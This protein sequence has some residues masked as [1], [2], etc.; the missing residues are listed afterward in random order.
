MTTSEFYILFV[1][2]KQERHGYEIMQQV[3]EDSEGGIHL[4]AG[5]LYGTIKRMLQENWIDE[6]KDYP[7]AAR[8]KMSERDSV[9][10]WL[11]KSSKYTAGALR[12]KAN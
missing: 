8:R 5:T 9:W 6:I 3:L 7:S 12:L 2:L 11:R 10:R 4:G 1:L